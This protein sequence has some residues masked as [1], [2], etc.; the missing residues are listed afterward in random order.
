MMFVVKKKRLLFRPT[1]LHMDWKTGTWIN[2]FCLLVTFHVFRQVSP[3][4]P[5]GSLILYTI[6]WR[7]LRMTG[8]NLIVLCEYLI[9]HSLTEFHEY[10]A[11]NTCNWHFEF[12]TFITLC[13]YMLMYNKTVFLFTYITCD[14]FVFSEIL[15]VLLLRLYLYYFCI[16][17][18]CYYCVVYCL[19]YCSLRLVSYP[20]VV[21]Q[22]FLFMKQ[23]CIYVCIGLHVKYPLFLSDFN[24]T[25][26]LLKN[27]RKM[28]IYQ[29]SWKSVQ[30][31]PSCFMQIDRKTWWGQQ[32]LFYNVPIY[33][34][35]CAMLYSALHN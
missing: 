12:L 14:I 16:V 33:Q 30:W 20:S 2:L 4:L 10:H 9:F 17:Y 3:T 26:I 28:L 5:R 29:F 27:C 34:V 24:V 18:L 25:W 23:I 32:S 6:I 21:Q 22:V 1:Y 13:V 11:N 15:H 8:C 7:V 19:V 35:L 31:E